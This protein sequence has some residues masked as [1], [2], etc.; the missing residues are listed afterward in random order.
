[1][2]RCHPD[3][4]IL[5][6]DLQ[7]TTSGLA[8]LKTEKC[9]F[10]HPLTCRHL[11]GQTFMY[12][13][14]RTAHELSLC[15]KNPNATGKNVD[16]NTWICA[17]CGYKGH[18][19]YRSNLYRHMKYYCPFATDKSISRIKIRQKKRKAGE[20]SKVKGQA[21]PEQIQKEPIDQVDLDEKIVQEN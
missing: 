14:S 17:K 5:E 7:P 8:N 1:M 15:P 21:K 10:G 4:P 12:E 19:W 3:H 16:G 6:C 9:T 20:N 13:P 18:S 2:K 11:C